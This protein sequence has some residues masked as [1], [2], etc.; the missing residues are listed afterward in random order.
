[1]PEISEVPALT[2]R[3]ADRGH[4]ETWLIYYDDI[5]IGFIGQRAGVPKN[6]NQWG[7]SCG[8]YP[9]LEPSQHRRGTAATFEEARAG[10]EV[11]WAALQPEIPSAAFD[12]YR[13]ERAFRAWIDGMW[14]ARCKLPTQSA[15][16]RS[17]CFCG[18]EIDLTNTEA[19]VYECHMAA[20]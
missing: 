14:E 16:G 5:N 20:A 4:Q 11:A 15:S 6:V 1:L 10:F 9:G 19:H 3:R 7:W 8:F 12:A 13:K 2:R 18:A 17:K